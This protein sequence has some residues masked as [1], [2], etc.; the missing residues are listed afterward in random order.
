MGYKVT[1]YEEAKQDIIE[2]AKWYDLKSFGLG[3]KFILLLDEAINRLAKN[4]DAYSCFYGEVRKIK[5]RKF[6][7]IIFYKVY[8]EKVEIYGVIH[9]KRNP[10]VYKKRL[11]KLL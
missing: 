4:P 9:V 5:L 6:P 3:D 2:I 1:L 10:S 8:N 11:R 7:Y